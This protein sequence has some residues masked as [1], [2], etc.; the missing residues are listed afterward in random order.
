MLGL[1][2]GQKLG[3]DYELIVRVSER[4][5]YI[6]VVMQEG[7]MQGAIL[8]GDTDLEETFENLIMN[9]LDLS[10]YGEDILNPNVDIEDYFD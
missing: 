2:N 8:I 9:Q 4:S 3:T 1:F 7:R 5:E 6:K 10:P